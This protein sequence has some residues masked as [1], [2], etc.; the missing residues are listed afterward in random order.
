ML[1]IWP[2]TV[3]PAVREAKENM[4]SRCNM[5]EMREEP[6]FIESD[7]RRILV[8]FA[9]LAMPCTGHSDAADRPDPC[10]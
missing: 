5:H 3:A 6:S 2:G 7:R 10:A 8:C 1:S 4:N 9:S